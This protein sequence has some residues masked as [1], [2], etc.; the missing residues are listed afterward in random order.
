[1]RSLL[2]AIGRLALC[3]I[4]ANT[5]YAAH[6]ATVTRLVVAFPPGG[7]ADTLA[8]LL[9]KELEPQLG[10]NV[11]VENRPG[12]NGA[13]AANYVMRAPADGSVL[14]LTSAGA[15]VINPSL[16]PKLP[17]DP[18]KDF[19]PISL[20]VNT[21]EVLVV[22]PKN[23]A[24]T[25]R[26]FVDGAKKRDQPGNIAS[27]GIGSMPH[28]A[29]A[30][31]NASTGVNFLHVAYKGAA[32]AITDTMGGH[33]DAFF[34]DVSGLMPFIN[35]KALKPIGVAA[36]ARLSALPDVPTLAE[37]GIPN[38]EASN[39]YGILAP[40]AVPARTLERLN[41]ALGKALSSK[42]LR[43]SLATQGV[44]PTATTPQEFARLIA[45]DTDKWHRVI[46]AGHIRGE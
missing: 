43:D 8:R 4:L 40:A 10:G 20:V 14:W 44:E 38:V 41:A 6:A 39:W 26:E 36:A 33:V 21:P 16:Y 37:L 19:A 3:L 28:M 5:A 35:E 15:V 1:M 34:G 7:P 23:P 24:A 31:F 42:T 17:Y 2:P 45:D 12:A 46:E 18:R 13:I 27:S 29:I 32:P 11:I 22:S 9:A 25:A 30:L